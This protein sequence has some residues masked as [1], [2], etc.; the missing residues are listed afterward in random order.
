[1]RISI[2]GIRVRYHARMKH[3]PARG[4][5]F[6]DVIVGTALIVIIF[7]ALTGLLRSSLQVTRLAKTRALATAIAESQMEYVRSLSYDQVGTVGGIPA[8]PISQNTTVTQNNTTFQ[9]RTLIVYIDDPAD[10]VGAADTNGITT[11]Y[12][13]MKVS[14]SYYANNRTQTIDLISNYAPP[15]LETTSNGGTLKINVVNASGAAVSGATVRILNTDLSPGVDLTTF[16]DAQGTVFLPGAQPSTQYQVYVSKNGYSS[17]QTYA[18]DSSNANP[19]PGYLTVV[20]SQTT[21]GTFAIDVLATLTVQTFSPIASST[22]SDSFSSNANIASMNSTQLNS[23]SV[24]LTSSANGY[25]YSGTVQSTVQSPTYLFRWGLVTAASVL[26]TGTN[27]QLQVLDGSGNP[28]PDAV[29]P[30]NSTGFTNSVDLWN[31]STSTYPSL[32]LSAMLLTS[33]SAVTPVLNSWSITYARGPVPLPAVGFSLSGTKSIGSTDAGTPILKTTLSDTTDTTGSRSE[34]LEWDAYALSVPSY[35]MIQACNPPPYALSPGSSATTQLIVGT[36]TQNMV[37]VTVRNAT[38]AIAGATVT[39]T[40][41]GNTKVV[42]SDSCGSTYFGG[43][44]S[45]TY[46]ISVAKT[47]YT[48][49]NASGVTVSGHLFYPVT[50]E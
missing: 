25:A 5:S 36:S 26:P 30:G 12:K 41:G 3:R 13:R 47:G 33:S 8:G 46:L 42:T 22:F 31:V 17:A 14:V 27:V 15:G 44:T 19:Q 18:R 37:L 24:Q 40:N 28:L 39:L 29:L 7:T 21:T 1:M 20:R 49:S 38:S 4:M 10:G 2:E 45:G 9:V 32:A 43:L 6:V 34:S 48:T 35:D 16:S 11:D 50:L 23:G